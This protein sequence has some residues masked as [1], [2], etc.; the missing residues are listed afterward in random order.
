M[1]E[2]SKHVAS[3]AGMVLTSEA[4]FAG[5]QDMARR[6]FVRND[7]FDRRDFRIIMLQ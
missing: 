7:I 5:K 3:W 6:L 1:T 4:A 2:K